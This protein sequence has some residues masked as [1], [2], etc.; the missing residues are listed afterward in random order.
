MAAHADRLLVEHP[1]EV[2]ELA[3]NL[4]VALQNAVAAE[5]SALR[6]GEVKAKPAAPDNDT[7]L[8]ADGLV[9]GQR[10]GWLVKPPY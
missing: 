8:D 7:D 2:G 9:D 3:K 5:H 4:A 1:R 10:L 6:I